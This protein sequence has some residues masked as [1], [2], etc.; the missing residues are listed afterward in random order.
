MLTPSFIPLYFW[1]LKRINLQRGLIFLAGEQTFCK[2]RTLPRTVIP[3]SPL[4]IEPN[5]LVGIQQAERVQG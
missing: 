4:N 2:A 3:S 5:H 1:F